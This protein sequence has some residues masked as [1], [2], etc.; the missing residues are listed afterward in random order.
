MYLEEYREVVKWSSQSQ[1]DP[2]GLCLSWSPGLPR[3]KVCACIA[4][5]GAWGDDA[6]F[7]GLYGYIYIFN[8][9]REI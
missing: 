3:S 2:E 1:P 7:H 9:L 6:D 4:G 8:R 5:F